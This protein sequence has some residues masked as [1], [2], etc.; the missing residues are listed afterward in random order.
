MTALDWYSERTPAAWAPALALCYAGGSSE[1][2]AAAGSYWLFFL[3]VSSEE[4]GC[5]CS[6]EHEGAGCIFQC[7]QHCLFP[8]AP[9]VHGHALVLEY[10]M[11]SVGPQI[12]FPCIFSSSLAIL[13]VTPCNEFCQ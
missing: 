6:T 2:A 13:I 12:Y 9:G 10:K 8:G 11:V 5:R 7:I 3:H 1:Q 4:L